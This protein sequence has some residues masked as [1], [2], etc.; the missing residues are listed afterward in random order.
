[1][2]S[3]SLKSAFSDKP[4]FY[5]LY[6]V[7]EVTLSPV[8]IINFSLDLRLLLKVVLTP[9]LSCFSSLFFV[10]VLLECTLPT[11]RAF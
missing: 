9:D 7:L 4:T 10:F 8:S 5:W 6:P 1:M 3:T 11:I 2:S